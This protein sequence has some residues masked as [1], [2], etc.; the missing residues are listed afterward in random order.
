MSKH[1]DKNSNELNRI[2][3]YKSGKTRFSYKLLY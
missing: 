1:I 2:C 3:H